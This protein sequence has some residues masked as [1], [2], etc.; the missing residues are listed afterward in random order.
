MEGKGGGA[1]IEFTPAQVSAVLAGV[2]P[3]LSL[4]VGPPGTG[5]TDV[6]TQIL[7]LLLRNYANERV[8]LIT[9]S[10]HAL[11]DLFAKMAGKPDVPTMALLRLGQG[12]EALREATEGEWGMA[13]RVNA[14]LAHRQRLLGDVERLARSMG[15]SA[16]VADGFSATCASAVFSGQV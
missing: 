10:N 16:D 11:N 8:L 4:V 13:G 9:H 2:Q 3:G 15:L 14:L 1:P 7:R 12:E 6:A 5:K